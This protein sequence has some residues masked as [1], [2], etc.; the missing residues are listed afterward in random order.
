MILPEMEAICPAGV[1]AY[2]FLAGAAGAAA[3]GAFKALTGYN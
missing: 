2:C 3:A 1:F